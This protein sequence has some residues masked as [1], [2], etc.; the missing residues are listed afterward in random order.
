MAGWLADEQPGVATVATATV[1][2][3]YIAHPILNQL[4]PPPLQP[5][6]GYAVRWPAA[7]GPHTRRAATAAAGRACLLLCQRRSDLG[8]SQI[9]RYGLG[10][11]FP[12]T[13]SANWG[14][15]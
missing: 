7:P 8:T 10:F 2:L 6:T 5:P 11:C 4:S 13:R 3:P 9:T 14:M 12:K 15:G 1:L